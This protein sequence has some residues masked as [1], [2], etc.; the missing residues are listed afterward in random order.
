M[1]TKN[2]AKGPKVAVDPAQQ[3]DQMTEE[4]APASAPQDASE[5]LAAELADLRHEQE[6]LR[7]Q[8]L[9][10]AADFDNYR[11]RVERER[12]EMAE[13]AAQDLLLELLPILDDFERALD[14]VVAPGAERYRDGVELIYR[15]LQE[16]LKKRGVIPIEAVG[17]DFDPHVH[18]A[19]VHEASTTHRDGE[20]IAELRRGYR[21]GDRLLR[22]VMVKVAKR[23]QA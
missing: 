19:V 20:V 2:A 4:G 12:R 15:Q 10:K 3:A 16:L 13:L 11:K 18:Q 21:L 1:T 22:P 8:L 23:E 6:E 17:T 9:R 7:N 14:V 5:A